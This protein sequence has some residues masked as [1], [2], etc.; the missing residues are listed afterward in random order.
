MARVFKLPDLGEG[1]HEGEVLAVHVQVGQSIAEG[2]LILTVETDKAAV[3]IPSPFG[4]VV[5]AIEVESGQ[6]VTVG[7]ILMRFEETAGSGP[8][9]D[10]ERPRTVPSQPVQDAALQAP[11]Q[12]VAAPSEGPVPASPATRRLA[13]ELGVTLRAVTPSGPHGLVTAEDVRAAA[14]RA[15][16]KAQAPPAA[17]GP[18]E[19]A[20]RHDAAGAPDESREAP[21]LPDFSHWGAV[22]RVPYR[23][24]RRVTGRQMALSWSQIPHVSSQE[25]AN[26]T[27][28]AQFRQ[29]HKDA[30][31]AQ[32]GRLTYTVFA[33]KAAVAAL[34]RFPDAN[35]SLDLASGE[36]VRKHYFH[37]GVAVNTDH[38]LMVPV[39]RDVDRKSLREL[40]IELQSLSERARARKLGRD[41]M[42]GG[43]FT[44][45]NAGA[46]GGGFF[47]PLINY[48]E[49]AIMGLG[50]AQMQPAA[51]PDAHGRYTLLPQL[52]LPLVLSID[53][54]VLD[55][56]DA[57]GFLEIVK[58]LLEDPEA[59]L[60]D[61][62]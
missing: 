7:Q 60:L 45:T 19:Q 38:G 29:D 41:E 57:V 46:M 25:S 3:E 13:R 33:L 54:R 59:L 10:V 49:V 39:I 12:P 24:I 1:V 27:R 2:D 11:E 62:V 37:I 31:A 48:P 18:P 58:S 28:L 52:L 26:V 55:G 50:R 15:E 53:H 9:T 51:V 40:A 23:S 34:K 22:Q 44:L 6:V 4:G 47:T 20:A 61:G 21:A 42:Q 8:P 35:A 30:V 32:G 5:S 36:I 16:A 56:A 14:A 17:P 43:T